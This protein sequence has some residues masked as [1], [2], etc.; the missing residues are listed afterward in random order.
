MMKSPVLLITYRRYDTTKRVFQS[1]KRAQPPVLYFASNGPKPAHAKE[2]S[3]VAQVRSLISEVDWPCEVKTLIRDEHLDVKASVAGAID[4][5][6]AHEPE[7]IVLEDDCLPAVDFYRFCDDMLE[8]FREVDQVSVI[9]GVCRQP[10]GFEAPS[11][12][13]FSKY[14]HI[15][16]WATWRRT[17]D[18]YDR[19]LS[20]WPHWQNS[21]Q[22][23]TL[24]RHRHEERY[25]RSRF[26]STFRGD[27][28]TWDY[29]L[30]ASVWR[31]RGLTLTPAVNLVSN[32]GFG[33]G[34]TFTKNTENPLSA[35]PTFPIYPLT[36]PAA[37]VT[38]DAADEFDFEYRF[39]GRL[40]R[41]P[42]RYARRIGKWVQKR[43][44]D[45]L[46]VRLRGH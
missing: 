44:F 3:E 31:A 13:Y 8:R 46:Y 18:L 45:P 26:D 27:T 25:W 16:G 9:S 19:D 33:D 23:K 29:Q 7:G 42:H 40:E 37:L 5:F 30:M 21:P 4:W 12:Y 38:N 28:V 35:A 11:S 20:F 22:W 6:F 14:V 36:H 1:I 15:W 34:A 10:V 39:N 43:V 41:F 2:V 24:F 32:I 17:W